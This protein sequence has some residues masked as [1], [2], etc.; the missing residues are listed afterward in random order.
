K[1]NSEDIV[2]RALTEF[3][4][5]GIA[6]T[7][8]EPV[9]FYEMMLDCAV[10]AKSKELKNVVV[11]NG[12]VNQEPLIKLLPYIDAFNIDLK[13]FNNDFYKK[14][15][16]GSIGPVLETLKT[17]VTSGKHLEITFLAITGLNDDENEFR[18]MAKWISEELG[19]NIPLHISRYFPAYK[20]T[21]N[22]TSVSTLENFYDIASGFLNYVYLGNIS[23]PERSATYCPKCKKVLIKRDRYLIRT[24]LSNQSKCLFCGAETGIII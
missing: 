12:F 8:N 4:N 2:D 15:T 6:Y 24:E 7:Y 10:I 18:K 14:Q 23:D 11:S 13:A 20:Q 16:K 19:E 9:V 22:T 5:I 17:I 1:L 21:K 3:N